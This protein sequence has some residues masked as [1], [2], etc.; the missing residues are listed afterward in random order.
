MARP[1]I[2]DKA[3]AHDLG[4]SSAACR[5]ELMGTKDDGMWEMRRE[6]LGVA[7]QTLSAA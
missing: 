7:E 2:F 4:G 6:P 3:M 5:G 1:L